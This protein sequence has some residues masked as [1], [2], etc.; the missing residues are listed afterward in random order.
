MTRK[1]LDTASLISAYSGTMIGAFAEAFNEMAKELR[2][3]A[4]SDFDE[5]LN[6]LEAKAIRSIEN[7]PIDGIPEADQLFLIEHTRSAI[8]AIFKTARRGS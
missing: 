3:Y 2:A 1:S 4:G 8:A 5:R 6:I 7:A